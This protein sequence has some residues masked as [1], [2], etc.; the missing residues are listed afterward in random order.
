MKFTYC[1]DCGQK[2]VE[3]E[4]GDE[5][6]VPW[7]EHCEKPWFDMFPSCIIALVHDGKGNVVLLKQNYISSIYRNLVSGYMQPGENAE[8]AA[9]REI[10]EEIGLEVKH[11][12]IAGTWW[13]GKKEMLMIGFFAETEN[14]PL[15]L[16]GEVDAAEWYPVDKAVAMVHPGGSV[17]YALT[18]EYYLRCTKCK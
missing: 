4:I 10:Q 18:H 2:L 13:F 11:L 14:I 7:C 6:L 12:E 17:S 1:P 16:S 15:H 3:K 9:K 8:N 5:G